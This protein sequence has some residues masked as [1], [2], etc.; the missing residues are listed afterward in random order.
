[1][2]HKHSVKSHKVQVDRIMLMTRIGTRPEI[3]ENHESCKR[4]ELDALP[5]YMSKFALTM[6]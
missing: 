2:R 6:I 4:D 1:M 5:L 3:L